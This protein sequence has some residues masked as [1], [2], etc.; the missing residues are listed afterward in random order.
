M[1]KL[2]ISLIAVAGLCFADDY[3]PLSKT[4]LYQADTNVTTTASVKTPS[5]IGQMLIGGKGA[6]TNAVWIAK[7]VTT[8]DWVAVA[9]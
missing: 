7:G 4:S 8:N 5:F 9:P 3:A 1:K 2:I 6:G